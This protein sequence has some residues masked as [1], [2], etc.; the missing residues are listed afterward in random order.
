MDKL[1]AVKMEAEMRRGG[2]PAGPSAIIEKRFK[3]E[4]EAGQKRSAE[5]M[6]VEMNGGVVAFR[7]STG[8]EQHKEEALA[9]RSLEGVRVEG[10]RITT[11]IAA[12]AI[13]NEWPITA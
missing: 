7:R 13:G 12:G 9:P 1:D 8:G 2:E 6:A 4:A 10:R 5:T 3:D 11:T